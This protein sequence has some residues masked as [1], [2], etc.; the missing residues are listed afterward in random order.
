MLILLFVVGGYL[1][2]ILLLI[3]AG[4]ELVLAISARK[5]KEQD[6]LLRSLSKGSG[7]L[8]TGL[9]LGGMTIF[10]YMSSFKN[11][12]V[13][14]LLITG[15]ICFFSGSFVYSRFQK[16]PDQASAHDLKE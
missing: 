12:V 4:V 7:Y 16:K 1:G 9:G 8:L 13:G 14:W 5:K 10:G 2:T 15:L 6:S 3:G 11:I